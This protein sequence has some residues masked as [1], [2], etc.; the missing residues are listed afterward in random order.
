VLKST[1]RPPEEVGCHTKSVAPSPL[2]HPTKAYLPECVE[3]GY[4]ELRLYGVL[5]SSRT[6][7]PREAA[8]PKSNSA[9]RPSSLIWPIWGMYFLLREE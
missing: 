8:Q 4:C 5:R 2:A 3:E 7:R 9:E 6:G 1:E